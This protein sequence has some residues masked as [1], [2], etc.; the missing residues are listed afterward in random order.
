MDRTA[1]I[2]LNIIY[3]IIIYALETREYGLIFHPKRNS[4]FIQSFSDSDFAGDRETR[5]SVYGYLEYFCGMTIAWKSNSMRSVV[6]L[7]TEAENI[8]CGE[9]D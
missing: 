5:R 4:G 7:S 1:H 9:S 6:L 8:E 3:R 2:H